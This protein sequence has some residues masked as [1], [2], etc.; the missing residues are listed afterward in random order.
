MHPFFLFTEIVFMYAFAVYL[1]IFKKELAILY[2]PVIFFASKLVETSISAA[3]YY[4]TMT[5]II[6]LAVSKNPFFYR[7]NP[8]AI[9][10]FLYF[11]LL[12]PHSSDLVLI[13]PYMFSVLWFFLLIPVIVS[14]YEKYTRET[15]FNELAKSAFLMLC[16]FIANVVLSTMKHYA[17]VPMYGISSGIL[18]GNLIG[19]SFN[20]LSLA[21]FVVL[22]KV[23]KSRNVLYTV[24]F[25]LS[26][27]FIML[28]LRRSVM[29]MSVLGLFIGLFSLAMQKKARMMLVSGCI[30]MAIGYLVISNTD[31]LSEF[32]ERVEV[33]KLDERNLEEEQRFSEYRFLYEDMFVYHMYSPWF[34]F[35]LFNS[36]GNYGRGEF[37][38]RSLHGDL[39]SIAHSSGIL[40][41]IL[42]LFMIKAA[43]LQALRAARKRSDKLIV[44]FCAANFIM[45]T[46]TGRFTQTD[47]MVL[48]IL[49]LM[50][51]LTIEDEVGEENLELTIDTR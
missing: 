20:S 34:G 49:V 24:V 13:R 18:Y 16:L 38:E 3:A 1:A 39:T 8:A 32:N 48:I 4:A 27:A 2:L 23:L 12:L 7:K 15:I 28:T 31:F 19:A 33:R 14:I 44:L 51:P 11:I 46:I 41:V 36:W 17:P 30:A 40:G 26:F 22:L 50:L 45:Y 10:L 47:A 37:D 42:Y 21:L 35:E 5:F 25:I 29:M 6:L 9:L 43:F